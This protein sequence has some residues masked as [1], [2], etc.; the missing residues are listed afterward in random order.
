MRLTGRAH[1]AGAIDRTRHH[2]DPEQ[3]PHPKRHPHRDTDP[4]TPAAPEVPFAVGPVTLK[5]ENGYTLKFSTAFNGSSAPSQDPTDAKPGYT[6]WTGP[7]VSGSYNEF[8]E[9]NRASS[10]AV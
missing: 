7:N 10:R 4:H 2:C 1:G 8:H 6:V 5:D 9:C 3:D